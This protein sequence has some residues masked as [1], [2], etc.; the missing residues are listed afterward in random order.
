[1]GVNQLKANKAIKPDYYDRRRTN[2]NDLSFFEL[3]VSLLR[4]ITRKCIQYY[5]QIERLGAA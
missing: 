3:M 1:M 5:F 2:L 4:G